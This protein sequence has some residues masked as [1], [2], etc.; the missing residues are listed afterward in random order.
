MSQTP[1]ITHQPGADLH[2]FRLRSATAVPEVRAVAYLLE[3]P[4]SGAR[5]LHL[6]AADPENLFSVSFPTPAP[7]DTGVAHILEHCVLAGS[8]RFPVREPFFEMIKMSMATFI[9][10]MTGEDSTFYPVASNVPKDLF[11]LAEVY[12]DA[13]FHPLLTEQTFRREGHHL[14]PRQGENGGGAARLAISGIVYNEMKGAFSDPD[15]RLGRLLNHSLLPDT[16][17][18]HES[19]GTPEAIPDLT[20]DFFRRYHATYY[21]PSNAYF[22]AYGDVPTADYCRFLGARLSGF[23]RRPVSWPPG[24]GGGTGSGDGDGSGD[25][26]FAPARQQ[27]WREAR[28]LN[29]S[30][31]IG[32][33][34]PDAER[35]FLVNAWLTGDALDPV[36]AALMRIL[37]LILAGNE[38]APLRKAIMQSKLGADLTYS[39]SSSVGR[40]ATFLIGLRGSESDRA[41][42]FRELVDD[43]LRSIADGGISSEMVETAFRQAA[44]EYLE[45]QPMFPLHTLFRVVGS[46]IYG[47]DPLTFLRLGTHLQT[48]RARWEQ[49][50]DLFA[51]LLRER[52]LR[53]P[54]RLNVVMRPDRT[55]QE[56]LDQRLAARVQ[57]T[58]AAMTE[59]QIAE[60]AANAAELE[61]LN[62]TPNT[63]EQ[64]ASL[65]QLRVDDLPAAL[66]HVPTE[67]SEV[68]G[69]TL[70][71]NDVFSNGVNYLVL[72]FDL[73][74]LPAE[75]W[76]FLPRYLG[77]TAKLGVAGAGY[78]EV[79]RRKAAA[80]GGIGAAVS[81]GA[82]SVAPGRVL[83]GVRFSLKALDDQMEEALAILDRV[84]FAVDPRDRAR[85]QEVLLQARMRYRTGLV[86]NGA[87]TAGLHAGRGLDLHG[88]LAEIVNGLPQLALC[89]RLAG[90]FEQ[91]YAPLTERIEQIRDFLL[92]RGRLTVSHTG[93]E[94]G[95]RCID[96]ALADW[97]GRLR[98]EPISDGDGDGGL[99]FTPYATPP[100]EGLAAQMHVA[101]CAQAMPAPHFSQPEAVPLEVAAHVVNLD[102]ILPEIRF[103]GNAYGAWFRYDSLNGTLGLGSYRD[104]HVTHTLDVF[105]RTRDYVAGAAWSE[106]DVGRAVIAVA[107]RGFTPLRPRPATG[108]ALQRHLAGITPE[109]REARH[110]RLKATTAAEVKRAVELALEA[111]LPRSAVCVVSSR[112][113]LEQANQEL[114]AAGQL[115]IEEILQH[116]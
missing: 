77:A 70:L 78:E 105:A 12:F 94:R 79:A 90:S 71:R 54:H 43:T 107:K 48:C 89:E 92:A 23:E 45:V 72:D 44:F 30:Y 51:R 88:H 96:A 33:A 39:G 111:G 8:R 69:I 84:V 10:A 81:L 15:A 108:L 32:A 55:M 24:A 112:E 19:G 17:Y 27:R 100:R 106:T 95:A 22:F 38:A 6:H 41:G 65:P 36:D 93:T 73:T 85:L 46:W 82:H 42:Q 80:T 58:E 53:N 62:S 114:G 74:G 101:Y 2:G 11:N 37:S 83:R 20:Y 9:N 103:K 97:G 28:L 115:T 29:E 31:P 26:A 13:T 52:L 40:E 116:G 75:L 91:E 1:A 64:L 76:P 87:A 14:A 68:A 113:K 50:P 3:H 21:H 59:E 57:R 98:D 60:T 66:Q 110:E 4:T 18:S 99:G 104:P 61:Q 102:W 67:Q 109:M 35:T 47:A 25:S 7:D 5:L 56:R 49:E 86:R 16:I 34:E 63:P